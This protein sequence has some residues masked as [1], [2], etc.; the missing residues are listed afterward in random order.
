[1]VMNIFL[2]VSTGYAGLGTYEKSIF[3]YAESILSKA[4]LLINDTLV[5]TN[6][7]PKDGN[8]NAQEGVTTKPAAITPKTMVV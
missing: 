6:T 1:M 5:M 3:G 8:D 7:F 4:A 2:K